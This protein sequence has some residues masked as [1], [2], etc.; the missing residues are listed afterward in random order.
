MRTYPSES[1]QRRSLRR[2][3]RNISKNLKLKKEFTKWVR[4][5]H[6][7]V[8]KVKEKI[9]KLEMMYQEDTIIEKIE[10]YNADKFKIHSIK[11]GMEELVIRPVSG[12]RHLQL[13]N[14]KYAKAKE[15]LEIVVESKE[16]T[17]D[18]MMI[19]SGVKFLT[20][21]FQRHGKQKERS[22]YREELR[23]LRKSR[24]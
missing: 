10:M 12:P 11:I 23:M 9:E 21:G 15:K 16:N 20:S 2:K 18:I 24:K 22:E 13:V 6:I 5:C 4:V 19:I 3:I 14:A 17:E 1:S 7:L 8:K